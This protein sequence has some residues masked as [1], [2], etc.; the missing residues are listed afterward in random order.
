[1]MAGHCDFRFRLFVAGNTPNS[2]LALL[3]LTALCGKLLIGRHEIEVVDVLDEPAQA[4]REGI[5][6]TPTLVKVLPLPPGRVVDTLGDAQLV[7][8]ALGLVGET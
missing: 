1:M 7:A 5:Y 2:R 8:N 4:L 6:M 3:N